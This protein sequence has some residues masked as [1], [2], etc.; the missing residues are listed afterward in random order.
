V[1]AAGSSPPPPTAVLHGGAPVS[2]GAPPASGPTAPAPAGGASAA[3][4][5]TEACPL[6]GTPLAPD[7][8]WCLHCGAAARTRLA[9]TSNWKAPVIAVGILALASLTVLAISLVALA[10]NGPTATTVAVTALTTPPPAATTP[11]TT[12]PPP[13]TSTPTT[14]TPGATGPGATGSTG[15]TSG[16]ST[17]AAGAPVGL[18]PVT[19]LTS[20]AATVNGTVN[21]QGTATTYQFH[22]S[23]T[24]GQGWKASAAPVALGS[25]MSAIPV[26]A[27]IA[28]L[29]PGTAYHYTLT[30]SKTG[31]DVTTPE[32]TFTT[33]GKAGTSK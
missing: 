23:A 25:G 33:P 1:S 18:A 26:N 2:P 19:A 12:P 14:A 9:T 30:A 29:T 13:A 17:P 7:Q 31:R 28:Y 15:T 22:F 24:A 8:E 5:A 27:R 21:P 11:T 32:A 4:P 3:A 16:A 10:G 6:C 20:S